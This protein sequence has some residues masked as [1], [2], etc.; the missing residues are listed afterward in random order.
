MNQNRNIVIIVLSLLVLAVYWQV[1]SHEFIAFDDHLYVTEN[2]RIQ[3]GISIGTVAGTFRDVHT[4]HWHPLT[5]ISHMVDWSLFGDNA[6]G[7]HWVNVVFHLF[8]T[9]L[10]FLLFHTMTGALWRSALVA[11]LFAIHPMNVESVAWVAERKNVLSTFFWLLTMLSYV[12]YVR[13]PDWKRYLPVFIC[14]V[15]GLMSKPMLVTLPF[16]LLLMDYWPLQR[17]QIDYHEEEKNFKSNDAIFRQ[18]WS[19]LIIEKIPLFLINVLSMVLTVYAAK[20]VHTLAGFEK[21]SLLERISNALVSYGLY[22]RKLIW[23]VDLSVFYPYN[24]IPI[25][26]ALFAALFLLGVT[27]FVFIFYKKYP[28]LI[29]GWLFYLGTLVPVIGFVQVGKQSMADRYVYIPFIGLF[30]MIAWSLP[31]M[32]KTRTLTAVAVTGVLMLFTVTSYQYVGLW[33]N[34]VLLFEDI[35]RHNPKNHFAYNILGLAA[36]DRGEYGNAL[37]SFR[38]ALKIKPNFD[39]AYINA[40]SIFLNLGNYNQAIDCYKKAVLINDLLPENHNNLGVALMLTGDFNGGVASFKKALSLRP[41]YISALNNLGAAQ[42]Q[43][44]NVE[45]ALLCYQQ[46]LKLHPENATALEKIDILRNKKVQ[47][48]KTRSARP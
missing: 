34:T 42:T 26:W 15:L 45:E 36:M 11:A 46:V 4:G 7:H 35:I 9:I 13:A 23:P 17:T 48:I 40:G 21:Y 29:I 6:G 47:S 43:M 33:E 16:V 38:V 20:S 18:T 32:K 30:I 19:F 37:N 10:L 2:F 25:S 27:V 12:R 1:Q 14:F 31:I 8:N 5:M 41:D 44:G 28:H 24:T 39:P 3:Q 22:I